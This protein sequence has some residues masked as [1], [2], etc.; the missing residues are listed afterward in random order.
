LLI[1]KYLKGEI[2]NKALEKRMLDLD[3]ENTAPVIPGTKLAQSET[4]R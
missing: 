2:S 3:L 1:E 4:K